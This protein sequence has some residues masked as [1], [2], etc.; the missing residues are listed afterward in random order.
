MGYYPLKRFKW[1]IILCGSSGP[2]DPPLDSPTDRLVHGG[3]R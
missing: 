1:V 3:L 2:V